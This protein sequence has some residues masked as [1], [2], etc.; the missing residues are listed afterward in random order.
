MNEERIKEI[1]ADESFVKQLLEQDTPEQ[2][3]SLLASKEID[4]SIA[5]IEKVC[6]LIMKQINGEINVDELSDEDLEDVAGG[7]LAEM[8]LLI[9]CLAGVAAV[10]AGGSLAGGAALTH[11]FTRRRW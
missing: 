11:Y 10:A 1:F 5:E 8:I 7:A 9:S 2:V 4:L 3:Q 6:E